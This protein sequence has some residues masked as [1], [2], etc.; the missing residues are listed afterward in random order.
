MVTNFTEDSHAEK[1][2]KNDAKLF[3]RGLLSPPFI[4]MYQISENTI[5]QIVLM[6]NRLHDHA[7]KVQELVVTNVELLLEC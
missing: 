3:I 4:I 5:R 7:K 1:K 2:R 6:R